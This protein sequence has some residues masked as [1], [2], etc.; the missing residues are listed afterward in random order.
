MDGVSKNPRSN[1]AIGLLCRGN[2]HFF[3]YFLDSRHPWRSPLRGQLRCS[4]ALLRAQWASKESDPPKAE[5]F[6]L[7]F[8]EKRPSRSQRVKR[9]RACLAEAVIHGGDSEVFLNT[10]LGGMDSPELLY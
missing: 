8:T 4:R 5:A 7:C 1:E 9:L 6:D 2:C 3:G 10:L